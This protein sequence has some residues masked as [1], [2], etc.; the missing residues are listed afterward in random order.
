VRRRCSGLGHHSAD[1]NDQP[2]HV[3]GAGARIGRLAV[4]NRTWPDSAGLIEDPS[5]PLSVLAA[6]H[7]CCVA[8]QGFE[9]WK[10][11]PT[12]L[13]A[14]PARSDHCWVRTECLPAVSPRSRHATVLY[15]G[16]D[17]NGGVIVVARGANKRWEPGADRDQRGVNA[18]GGSRK[19]RQRLH[20][21]HPDC[22]EVSGPTSVL[23]VGPDRLDRRAFPCPNK[24][25]T[26]DQCARSSRCCFRLRITWL[27]Q[28]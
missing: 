5:T 9:P 25:S 10:H 8:G 17:R 15:P 6:D 3:S 16:K 14:G 23:R 26:T 7:L 11:Q 24:G 18:L 28:Q 27:N 2:P 4:A 12:D 20:W 22:P 13:Q 1:H 19:M 21:P